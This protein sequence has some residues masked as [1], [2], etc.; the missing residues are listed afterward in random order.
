MLQSL[1]GTGSCR[2]MAGE[3]TRCWLWAGWPVGA[4]AARPG[5]LPT[6]TLTCLTGRAV[7]LEL[8]RKMPAAR[9]FCPAPHRV[10]GPLDAGCQGLHPLAHLVRSARRHACRGLRGGCLTRCRQPSRPAAAVFLWRWRRADLTNGAALHALYC[11][12]PQV[13]PPQHLPGRPHRAGAVPVLQGGCLGVLD[14]RPAWHRGLA[15]PLSACVPAWSRR[16]ALCCP[17]HRA[18]RQ[19]LHPGAARDAGP[20]PGVHAGLPQQGTR[21][22]G[23]AAARVRAQPHGCARTAQ[24]LD[25]QRGQA[26]RASGAL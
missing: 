24:R 5:A 23:G 3:C 8:T 22:L 17:L 10:H 25:G 21:G 15:G 26:E 14:A 4:A 12:C 1:S 20:G 16:R 18:N 13:Q 2:L 6:Q 19:L 11:S 7:G 9:L